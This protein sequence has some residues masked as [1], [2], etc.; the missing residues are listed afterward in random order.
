R[1][2]CERMIDDALVAEKNGLIG[3]SYIDARGRAKNSTDIRKGQKYASYDQSLRALSRLTEKLSLL[4]V[5]NDKEELFQ[6]GEC[7][8]AALYSGWYRYGN[9]LDAFDFVPGAIGYHLASGEASSL[10]KGNAWCKGLIEDGI[11]VTL[12]PVSEPY[13]GAFPPPE[14]FFALVF[15]GRFSIGEVFAM[16]TRSSSWKMVLIGDPMY[17]PYRN[18]PLLHSDDLDS[19]FDVYRKDEPPESLF[20]DTD[21]S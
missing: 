7:P 9:Y 15:S 17:N 10:R 8:N 2:V 21:E 20:L 16:T 3:I 19:I 5:F 6:E 12:G 18:N 4:T 1:R 11:T 14:L 13:L